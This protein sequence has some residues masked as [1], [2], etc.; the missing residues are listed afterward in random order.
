VLDKGAILLGGTACGV[1]EQGRLLVQ[2]PEGT[3][4][5]LVGEISIRRQA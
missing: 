3:Q 5:I 4:P 1:D 2:T